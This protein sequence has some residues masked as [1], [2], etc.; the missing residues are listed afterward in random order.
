MVDIDPL[1]E[2]RALIGRLMLGAR[3]TC[4]VFQILDM[5]GFTDIRHR[6]VYDLM[7]MMFR[8]SDPIDVESVELA[9]HRSGKLAW[10]GGG[11]ALYAMTA[12]AAACPAYKLLVLACAITDRA[13]QQPTPEPA[14][15]AVEASHHTHL[16]VSVPG[17]IL[18]FPV[19]EHL[20]PQ[21]VGMNTRNR[22]GTALYPGQWEDWVV[23][24]LGVVSAA[25]GCE[26]D[27]KH[28]IRQRC[29]K[30]LHD[31]KPGAAEPEWEW[32]SPE[33]FPGLVNPHQRVWTRDG[34]IMLPH[35]PAPR[36]ATTTPATPAA[37]APPPTQPTPDVRTALYWHYDGDGVLLYIGITDG[38]VARGKSHAARS[39]WALFAKTSKSVW[40]PNRPEAEAAEV[41]AIQ[42]E[43]PLFNH[44]HNDTPE[45]RARLVAY[46]I[47]HGRMDLLAP[48]VSR[49]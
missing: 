45:A 29:D 1:N 40:Y 22:C 38:L 28:F 9:L 46:L 14:I 37:V 5:D 10:V 4:E 25:E 11:A 23:E 24:G 17:G 6:Y 13:V 16:P 18:V 41:A 43:R 21:C 31:D 48:A 39:S 42:A 15:E 47:E 44:T 30:H 12:A 49:G 32:F 3:H 33:R 2:E 26:V 34:P 27:P 20:V 19:V 36:P 35:R 8:H 7:F